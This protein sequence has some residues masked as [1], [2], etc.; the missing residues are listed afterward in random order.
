MMEKTVYMI[1]SK[2]TNC[3]VDP[4]GYETDDIFQGA[5]YLTKKGAIWSLEDFDSPEDFEIHEV[6]IK[7]EIVRVID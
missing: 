6:K 2:L 4:E 3:Y 5:E 1:K 7:C